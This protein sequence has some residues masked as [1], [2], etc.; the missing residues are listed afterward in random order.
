MEIL[1]ALVEALRMAVEIFRETL[2]RLI[3]VIS[4]AL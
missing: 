1:D 4:R 2:G 3:D